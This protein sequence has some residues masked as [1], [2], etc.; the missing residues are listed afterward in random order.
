MDLS[1]GATAAK[2]AAK[3]T[4]EPA[5]QAFVSSEERFPHPAS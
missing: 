3:D 1:S 4:K 2:D 5:F